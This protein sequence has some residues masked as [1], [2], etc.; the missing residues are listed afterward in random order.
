MDKTVNITGLKLLYPSFGAP[1]VF[2][3]PPY[4]SSEMVRSGSKVSRRWLEGNKRNKISLTDE[5]LYTDRNRQGT[6][7][8]E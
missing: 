5:R 3:S 4:D 1:L 8:A 6:Y 7:L 2:L